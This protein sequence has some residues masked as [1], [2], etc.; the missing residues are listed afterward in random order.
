MKRIEKAK[1]YLLFERYTVPL[2]V[3]FKYF[4]LYISDIA[5]KHY[6]FK[7]TSKSSIFSIIKRVALN[8]VLL[9]L[10]DLLH[11]YISTFFFSRTSICIHSIKINKLKNKCLNFDIESSTYTIKT[12]LFTHFM[13]LRFII[14]IYN[15]ATMICKYNLFTRTEFQNRG[16]T[17]FNACS[18]TATASFGSN[19]LR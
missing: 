6:T 12:C 2:L 13:K 7:Y 16:I 19:R 15:S 8:F 17:T 10:P 9:S 14:P 5:N 1:R 11:I 4:T 3:F 18:S